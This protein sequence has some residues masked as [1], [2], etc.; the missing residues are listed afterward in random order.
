MGSCRL[1]LCPGHDRNGL[2]LRRAGVNWLDKL[3]SSH[4]SVSVPL[5]T[6]IDAVPDDPV[7]L[8]CVT[9]TS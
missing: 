4:H 9:V 5:R 7:T 1:C 6:V 2:G 3:T 8:P